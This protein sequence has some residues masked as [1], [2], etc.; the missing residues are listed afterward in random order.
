[1]SILRLVTWYQSRLRLGFSSR[2]RG[3]PPSS[4]AVAAFYLPSTAIAAS[5]PPSRLSP[6][7]S[8]AVVAT[9]PQPPAAAPCTAP[10]LSTVS[11]AVGSARPCSVRR[12]PRRRFCAPRP[13]LR[14]PPAAPSVLRAP[15]PDLR[16]PAV[17][18]ARPA[19]KSARPAVEICTV[20]SAPPL[21]HHPCAP[22]ESAPSAMRRRICAAIAAP[23]DLRPPA[24]AGLR[25][26]RI[27]C[28]AVLPFCDVARIR[29]PA[30]SVAASHLFVR[31]AAQARSPAPSVAASHLFVRR[32]A[33]TRSAAVL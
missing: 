8:S 4:A 28:A 5:Q 26:G 18:S 19:V 30:P 17:G 31:R 13:L 27:F 16:P 22:S 32:A 29:P 1:L 20:G 6:L 23:P 25:A 24:P 11:C 2:H 12:Q 33:Q 9:F 3:L 10:T 14:P 15:P 7:L 21:L